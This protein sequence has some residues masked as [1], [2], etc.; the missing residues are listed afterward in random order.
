MIMERAQALTRLITQFRYDLIMMYP[1]RWPVF[2]PW[3]FPL[4]MGWSGARAR[5]RRRSWAAP[6]PRSLYD[7]VKGGKNRCQQ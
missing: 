6:R 4:P 5:L 1:N 2:T 7:G 3:G